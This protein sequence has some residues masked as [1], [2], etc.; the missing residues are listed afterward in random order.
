MDP[1]YTFVVKEQGFSVAGAMKNIPA[2]KIFTPVKMILFRLFLLVFGWHTGMAYRIK[3]FIRRLLM[4]KSGCLPV[5]F[6]RSFEW[7]ANGIRVTDIV[8]IT[9]DLQFAS[10]QLGDEFFVRYVPQSRYFQ[11]QELDAKGWMLDAG[12]LDSLNHEKKIHLE[13][14]IDLKSGRV[15]DPVLKPLITGTMGL[16][17]SEGRK[18]NFR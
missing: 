2:N 12:M 18:K 13:R 10:L 5:L 8:K 9:G 4:L 16:E 15:S 17:Y 11:S 14:L 7:A 6:Y 3:G 1:R